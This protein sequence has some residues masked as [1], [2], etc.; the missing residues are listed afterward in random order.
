MC[1]EP[2]RIVAITQPPRRERGT[3]WAHG[4]DNDVR[5]VLG[6]ELQHTPSLIGKPLPTFEKLRI[7]AD[8]I[9]SNN[10]MMLLCF[11]DINQRPSRHCVK[12]LAG[13]AE[14][15]SERGVI[16]VL[17]HNGEIDIDKFSEWM[18]NSK[19]TLPVAAIT[20]EHEQGL[21][22]M[23]ALSLPWLILTD[24]QHIV[25]AEGFGPGDLERNLNKAR[26]DY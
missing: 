19:I 4:G 14:Y 20:A 18:K 9:D 6:S 25:I 24:K 5:V 7:E 2:L 22:S 21:L 1:K 15:L 3:T 23:G 11:F 10:R 17:V 26:E 12:Q 13:K 8:P 16:V